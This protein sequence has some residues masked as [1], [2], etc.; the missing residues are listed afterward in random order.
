MSVMDTHIKEYFEILSNSSIMIRTVITVIS[1]LKPGNT[2][3]QQ[4][5][6]FN[7]LCWQ[8]IAE[9]YVNILKTD[10]M[11]QFWDEKNSRRA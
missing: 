2:S 10:E 4:I 11:L 3:F 7:P 5:Y 8:L 9:I 6:L 1:F